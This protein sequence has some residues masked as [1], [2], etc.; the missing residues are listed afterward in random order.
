VSDVRV[1]EVRVSHALLPR[2]LAKLILMRYRA[3]VR[4]MVRGNA[5]RKVFMIV[6]LVLMTLYIVPTMLSARSSK[7]GIN[8]ETVQLWLPLWMLIAALFQIIG[9][10]TRP[11]VN[12]QPA[13]LDL[14]LP[15]PFSRRQ[16]IIYQLCYQVGPLLL[17]GIWI[18][19]FLKTGAPFPVRALG[20][21]LAAQALW[22]LNFLL[23]AIST[24]L[25]LRPVYI[26]V[27]AALLL[28]VF[29][30]EIWRVAPPLVVKDFAQVSQWISEILRSPRI[31]AVLSLLSPYARAMSLPSAGE[32]LPWAALALGINVLLACATIV[33]DRGEFESMSS[34][35]RE[36]IEKQSAT[37]RGI[38]IANPARASRLTLP[39]PPRG[40]GIGVL[41][42]RHTLGTY[43][44]TGPFLTVLLGSA[45]VGLSTSLVW[46][47]KEQAAMLPTAA[48]CCVTILI[49]MTMFVRADFREDLDHL[50]LLKTLPISPMR[51]V[52]GQLLTPLL[53]ILGVEILITLGLLI[54][55]RD[56]LMWLQAMGLVV[57]T[58]PLAAALLAIE[59]TVFLFAPTRPMGQTTGGFDPA[60]IGRHFLVSLV[61][62]VF[63]GLA[64][65]VV[66]GPAYLMLHFTKSPIAAILVA[67][68]LSLVILKG[69]LHACAA[70]FVRFN[71][72][73]DQPA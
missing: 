49:G 55:T 35:S 40:G 60:R 23:S 22:H 64:A 58:L 48:I 34:R 24:R 44:A 67:L 11:P 39:M 54:A 56:P 65:V 10:G 71:V 73:D 57:A 38:R 30:L 28:G 19:V 45:V 52:I 27:G 31:A 4:R 72:V 13:E 20:C 15:G 62:I 12:F 69:L 8:P 37:R 17:M 9:R 3:V 42:W 5:K 16:L 29:A 70:A 63:F 59:N 21:M 14:V 43:R 41:A 2:A 53:M 33:I 66:G 18:S 61:K 68:L 26:A 1:G 7:T 50:A 25:S 51:I 47:A 46:L 36:I 6:G 32:A